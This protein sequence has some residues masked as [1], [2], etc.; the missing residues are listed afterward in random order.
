LLTEWVAMILKDTDFSYWGILIA[1]ILHLQIYMGIFALQYFTMLVKQVIKH[2]ETLK[3]GSLG[4]YS[5]LELN[6]VI[7]K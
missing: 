5:Q 4:S 6:A 3:T 2:L 7:E 1:V